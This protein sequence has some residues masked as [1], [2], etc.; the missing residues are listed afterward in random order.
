MN[1]KQ[2]KFQLRELEI[3][4][5]ARQI[6]KSQGLAQ[7]RMP[8]LA[9]AAG[10]S[11]GSLYRHFE[12]REDVLLG[13]SQSALQFR[14][15]KLADYCAQLQNPKQ[16]VNGLILLDF[17]FNIAH[18]EAF[19]TEMACSNPQCLSLVSEHRL[20]SYTQA[21]EDIARCVTEI[22][23]SAETNSGDCKEAIELMATGVWGFITGMSN[24]WSLQFA[25]Q[26]KDQPLCESLRAGAQFIAPHLK[27]FLLG[28]N[29]GA[30]LEQETFTQLVEQIIRDAELWLWPHLPQ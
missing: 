2:Q 8:E 20:N 28:Y 12:R 13:L 10:V 11:V 1:N 9:K 21:N 25:E 24:V 23:H 3:L 26:F 22:L 27:A 7:L 17:F 14:Q 4:S 19:H 30:V 15:A 18:P 16:R 6:A 5:A 29:P